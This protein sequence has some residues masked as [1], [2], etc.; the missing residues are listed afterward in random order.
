M[1]EGFQLQITRQFRAGGEATGNVR[2]GFQL[3]LRQRR[4]EAADSQPRISTGGVRIHHFQQHLA[5]AF[6]SSKLPGDL[7]RRIVPRR[8]HSAQR[9]ARAGIDQAHA[10]QLVRRLI[11]ITVMA[12]KEK[13]QARRQLEGT[14]T[15]TAGQFF[16]ARLAAHQ[17]H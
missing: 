16:A 17:S 1:A 15:Q 5:P 4:R 3:Q 12:A 14:R 10:V 11:G 9:P 6:T 8:I 2:V 7:T 13:G